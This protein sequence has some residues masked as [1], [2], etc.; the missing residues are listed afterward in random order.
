MQS[1]SLQTQPVYKF[2][3]PKLKN[4]LGNLALEVK[5]YLWHEIVASQLVITKRE[6]RFIILR[7]RQNSL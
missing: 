3:C 2:C 1:E 7:F 6:R 4:R 5:A